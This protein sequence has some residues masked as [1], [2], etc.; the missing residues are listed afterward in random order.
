MAISV[1]ALGAVLFS[2]DGPVNGGITR[3]SPSSF[4]LPT[5][6]LY[7]VTFQVSVVGAGQLMLQLDGSPLPQSIVGRPSGT[8]QIVGTSL[9]ETTIPNSVLEVINASNTTPLIIAQ[10]PSGTTILS[11]HLVITQVK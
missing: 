2:T 9:I 8:G 11:S 3:A 10:G 4:N 1:P 6:G 5:P 7:Q